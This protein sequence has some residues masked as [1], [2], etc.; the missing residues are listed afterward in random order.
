M[1]TFDSLQPLAFGNF[2]IP[3]KK[4]KITFEGRHYV[5]EYPHAQGGAPEKLGRKCLAFH[6]D[7]KIDSA[8]IG[9]KYQ[10]NWPDT[11]NFLRFMAQSQDTDTLTIPT[12][13]MIPAFIVLYTEDRDNSQLSGFDISI[14]FLEDPTEAFVANQIASMNTNAI[15]SAM[16]DYALQLLKNTLTMTNDEVNLFDAIFG[17]VSDLEGLQ[18]QIQL[19]SAL[20]EAKF[21]SLFS[22]FQRA[23]A[24]ARWLNRPENVL[25]Y[26]AFLDLW[27]AVTLAYEDKNQKGAKLLVFTTT[28]DE[29]LTQ[30]SIDIFRNGGHTQDLLGLNAITD[31][32]NIPASSKIRYYL[33]D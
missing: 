27:Q 30:V 28:R 9:A 16:S 3:F 12:V 31:P 8:L 29:T 2:R 22:A 17:L 4:Y 10:G 33:A 20:A 19:Y 25:G 26:G 7:G 32:F 24:T 18:D 21:S 15:Q 13:G 14:D 6:V 23:D 11:A 1:A 5:H